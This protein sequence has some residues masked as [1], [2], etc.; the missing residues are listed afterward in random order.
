M[1]TAIHDRIA[2]YEV[3]SEAFPSKALATPLDPSA[4]TSEPMQAVGMDLFAAG[5][6]DYLVMVDRHSGYPW[7]HRLTTTTSLAVTRAI[8]KW[9]EYFGLPKSIRS[10]G[11]L[12]FRGEAFKTYCK[13]NGILHE[14]S[15]PYYP[16]SNGLAEAAIKNV[17]KLLVKCIKEGADFQAALA[18]SRK[19]PRADGCS[20]SLIMFRRGAR[21]KLPSL[22]ATRNLPA[23]G[24]DTVVEK[25]QTSYAEVTAG[26][27]I[28]AVFQPGQQV[29][30]Q[31]PSSGKWS[32]HPE[33]LSREGSSYT[34]SFAG[35]STSPRNE[36][37][38]RPVKIHEGACEDKNKDEESAYSNANMNPLTDSADADFPSF[39][40]GGGEKN[41]HLP[42][43]PPSSVSH[44]GLRRSAR[45][46]KRSE[47]S[48]RHSLIK[49][50]KGGAFFPQSSCLLIPS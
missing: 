29:W 34:I 7:V 40:G 28:P 14:T 25:R 39:P 19:C 10:D 36:R 5:G 22:P 17:K 4:S 12:Q 50:K 26:K 11:G 46:Q 47:E 45:L 15:S 38:L 23:A 30:V 3:C 42:T 41:F 1:N 9:F 8:K 24:A 48:A 16:E 32:S 6:N 27:R 49:K 20:P 44:L 2:G 33:V 31:D 37:F 21:G 18:E 43:L 13:D 35:G